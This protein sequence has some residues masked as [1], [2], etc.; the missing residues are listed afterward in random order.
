MSECVCVCVRERKRETDREGGG[1]EVRRPGGKGEGVA[2]IM[3]T[4][5]KIQKFTSSSHLAKIT[6]IE[7]NYFCSDEHFSSRINKSK[8]ADS[9]T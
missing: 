1:G 3:H 9:G 6:S 4:K 7:Q 2:E 5:H 8:Y